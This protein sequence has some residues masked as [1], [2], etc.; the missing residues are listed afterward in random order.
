MILINQNTFGPLRPAFGLV[1]ATL[2]ALT[3]CGGGGEDGPGASEGP[4]RLRV[5]A[6]T[7][8]IEDL[9]RQIAGDDAEVVG[10]MKVGEDPHVYDV[11]PNDAVTISE[12]DLILTNGL[13]LEATLEGVIAQAA[14]GV[15]VALAQAPGIPTLGSDDYE[16]APDPHCWMD[17]AYFK[18]YAATARDALADADP[19]HA[20]AYRARADA[21]IQE[22]DELDAWIKAQ[23]AA[24]PP[25]QRVVVTS[26]D[27][28]NYYARA[29]E[30]AVHGVVGISTDAQPKAADIEALR[31]MIKDRGVRALFVE[32]SVAPTLNQIVENVASATGATIGGSLYS[33]SLGAPDSP[34]G[35]YLGMMRHNT[36]TMVEALR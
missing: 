35:T 3:G 24:I 5:V 26:H 29:Y 22:L 21:Y 10:V 33:D 2:L 27:A 16:G 8:M 4:P 17:A 12:A 1:L 23:W 11:R 14:R 20:E 36:Q 28:F 6:T 19:D 9:A 15:V 25:D 34:G 7:T 31:Q 13:H 30:V 18:A 32:T